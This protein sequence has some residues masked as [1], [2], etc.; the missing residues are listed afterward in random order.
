MNRGTS[1]KKMLGVFGKAS[2]NTVLFFFLSLSV[3][4]SGSRTQRQPFWGS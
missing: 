2:L 3:L 1:E 4:V